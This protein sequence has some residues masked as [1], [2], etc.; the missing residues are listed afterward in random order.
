LEEIEVSLI[1]RNCCKG[2]KVG[3][4]ERISGGFEIFVAFL[5]I[6]EIKSL[7]ATTR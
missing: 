6:A 4:K 1:V 7:F 3:F 5:A 2:R